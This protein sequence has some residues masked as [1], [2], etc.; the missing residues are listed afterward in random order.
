M[1]MIDILKFVAL[2]LI[3][4]CIIGCQTYTTQIDQVT[5]YDLSGKAINIRKLPLKLTNYQLDTCNLLIINDLD[6]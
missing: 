1:K 5:Y 4:I 2:I 6:Q 3:T